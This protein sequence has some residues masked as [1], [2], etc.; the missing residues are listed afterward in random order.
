MSILDTY[1][2][3]GALRPAPRELLAKNTDLLLEHEGGRPQQRQ[4]PT[5]RLGLRGRGFG[6]CGP[7]GSPNVA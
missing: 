1:I 4:G 6:L 3:E 5:V 7:A 2:P